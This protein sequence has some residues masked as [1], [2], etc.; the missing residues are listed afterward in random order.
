[1]QHTVHEPLSELH[2]VFE[3]VND[4]IDVHPEPMASMSSGRPN[5]SPVATPQAFM[6]SPELQQ[7]LMSMVE[8]GVK[9]ALHKTYP[10]V[11]PATAMLVNQEK[12]MSRGR[13]LNVKS[14]YD[15]T[16]YPPALKLTLINNLQLQHG[17]MGKEQPDS[18]EHNNNIIEFVENKPP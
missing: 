5:I 6:Q 15:T 10:V 14:P 7:M 8:Q 4:K 12:V 16:V 17:N 2:E 18:F 9:L 1:M 13:N 3:A 11:P